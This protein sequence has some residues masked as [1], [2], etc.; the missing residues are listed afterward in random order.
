MA[1]YMVIKIFGI[2][3]LIYPF[4]YYFQLNRIFVNIFKL[5][6]I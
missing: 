3:Y 4:I 6:F 5:K 2:K 1:G